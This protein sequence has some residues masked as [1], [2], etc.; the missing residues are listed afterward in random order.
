MQKARKVLNADAHTRQ[1]VLALFK[2]GLRF[3]ITLEI[4]LLYL[5]VLACPVKV[6]IF[7]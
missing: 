6:Y 2:P 3:D 4:Q 1:K 7:I 5:P